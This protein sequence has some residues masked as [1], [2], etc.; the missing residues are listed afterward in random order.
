MLV[1]VLLMMMSSSLATTREKLMVKMLEE[2]HRKLIK[3]E[4]VRQCWALWKQFEYVF[5]IKSLGMSLTNILTVV[6][7]GMWWPFVG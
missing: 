7:V 6:V 5:T 4:N 3:K 1:L 2:E